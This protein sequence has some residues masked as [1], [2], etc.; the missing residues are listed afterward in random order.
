MKSY[1]YK[2]CSHVVHFI[3][4]ILTGG[5][6]LPIWLAFGVHVSRHNSWVARQ[7]ERE[8]HEEQIE[9]LRQIAAQNAGKQG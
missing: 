7:R 5:F 3:L 4:S 8:Q 2:S 1:H 9:L 6:W